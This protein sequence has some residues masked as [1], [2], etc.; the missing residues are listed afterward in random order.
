MAVAEIPARGTL[1]PSS[2][3]VL[4]EF[5]AHLRLER[6]RSPHTVRAYSGDV[7]SLLSYLDAEPASGLSARSPRSGG[8]PGLDVRLLRAWLGALAHSGVARS[9]VARRAAAARTFTAWAHGTGRLE[10]DPGLLLGV[11]KGRSHLPAVLQQDQAA[12]LMR[13]AAVGADDGSPVGLRDRA[14]MELLYAS[15]VRVGELVGLDVDDVD[16]ARRT[17][18]V[19]GKGGKERA[20]R[21]ASPR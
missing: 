13:V 8:V 16:L 7:A 20:C 14:L 3:H 18:R 4:A 10:T 21:S 6:D 5:V 19:L 15:G 12:E 1:S 17:A 2:A 11:P 9:T